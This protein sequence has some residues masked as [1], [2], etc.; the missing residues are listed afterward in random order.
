MVMVLYP[1]I[2][3]SP[4]VLASVSSYA[5]I[6]YS[7]RDTFSTYLLIAYTLVLNS[8]YNSHFER[9]NEM[10]FCYGVYLLCIIP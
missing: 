7:S 1:S 6:S 4:A 3:S 9:H 5:T 10:S 2:L 8:I